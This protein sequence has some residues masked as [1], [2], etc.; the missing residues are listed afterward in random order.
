MTSYPP[1]VPVGSRHVVALQARRSFPSVS[2]LITTET[3]PRMSTGDRARLHD[4]VDQASTRLCWSDHVDDAAPFVAALD[5]MVEAAVSSRTDRALALYTSRDTNRALLLG[6]EVADRVVID[7]T[8]AT[9]DLVLALQ[10]TPR[11]LVLVISAQQARLY[12]SSNGQLHAA[13]GHNFPLRA[14]DDRGRVTRTAP[15]SFLQRVDRRLGAYRVL[16]PSPLVV[17]GPAQVVADFV[18]TAGHAYRLAGTLS[19]DHADATPT[20]LAGLTRPIIQRYLASRENE[21][22]ALIATRA[23]QG[24]VASGMH[25]AWLAS[26]REQPEMLAVE[27]TLFYPARLSDD[28]HTLELSSDVDEPDVIDDAVDELIEHVLIRGGWV[29]LVG[30]GT[31]ARH[32][33]VA[34]V[35]R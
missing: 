15:V 8:F 18:Q 4:L 20:E 12:E 21:A 6:V 5:A 30:P 33:A 29:A 19:G 24:R 32:E 17:V 28:G 22:L 11:H 3:G 35:R 2:V 26:R 10:R 1:P 7:Q 31:L 16:H 34:L 13:A 14:A 9:R 27:E 23:A 25:A